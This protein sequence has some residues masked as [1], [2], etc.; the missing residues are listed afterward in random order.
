MLKKYAAIALGALLICGTSQ[1][2][3]GT[4]IAK[5]LVVAYAVGMGLTAVHE[6]GHAITAKLFY[7]CPVDITL[8]AAQSQVVGKSLTKVLG[9]RFG[10]FNPATGFAAIQSN[11]PSHP[12]KNACIFAC[13]PIFGAIGSLIALKYLPKRLPITKLVALFGL[14]NHTA[15]PAGLLGYYQGHPGHDLVRAANE[16]KNYRSA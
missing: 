14:L 13:G 4:K 8:G 11:K 3:P 12:L 5:D 9:F 15:G 7:D 16:I 1:A 2:I 6:L 10:G